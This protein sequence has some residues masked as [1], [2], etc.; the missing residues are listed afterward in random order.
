MRGEA[1]EPEALGQL[2]DGILMIQIQVNR[3]DVKYKPEPKDMCHLESRVLFG[4]NPFTQGAQFGLHACNVVSNSS[5]DQFFEG[6][7]HFKEE[8]PGNALSLVAHYQPH[9]LVLIH[10]VH[11]LLSLPIFAELNELVVSHTKIGGFF[12]DG[13]LRQLSKTTHRKSQTAASERLS[14]FSRIHI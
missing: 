7:W 8:A 9:L 4:F 1:R 13:L 10:I 12:G 11:S 3:N 5:A 14:A 2:F 6:V